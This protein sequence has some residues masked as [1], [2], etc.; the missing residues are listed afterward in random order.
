MIPE[1]A[2]PHEVGIYIA[3][4]V[5][6]VKSPTELAKMFHYADRSSVDRIL[7]KLRASVSYTEVH[8]FEAHTQ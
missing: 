4:H 5:M 7:K 3:Y 1:D 8:N 6:N 2:K